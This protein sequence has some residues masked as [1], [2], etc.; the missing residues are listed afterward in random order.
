LKDLLAGRAWATTLQAASTPRLFEDGRVHKFTTDVGVGYHAAGDRPR[1]RT[2]CREARGAHR[3]GAA[4][5]A[6]VVQVVRMGEVGLV[7]W[8]QPPQRRSATGTK[9]QRRN[10]KRKG[11]EREKEKGKGER[12]K[13]EAPRAQRA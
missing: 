6:G 7:A 4:R 12:G 2:S 10:R 8:Q 13:G 11:K 1:W 9:R 3:T 5:A